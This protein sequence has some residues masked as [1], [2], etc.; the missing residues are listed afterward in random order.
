MSRQ[1]FKTH[2][3]SRKGW[4]MAVAAAQNHLDSVVTSE[5]RNETCVEDF[6]SESEEFLT[7]KMEL[8]KTSS[9]HLGNQ[10]SDDDRSTLHYNNPLL[11]TTRPE[12]IQF[13][14][15]PTLMSHSL[16]KAKIAALQQKASTESSRAIR[17]EGP[18]NNS[19][20]VQCSSNL[21]ADFIANQ[22]KQRLI[23]SNPPMAIEKLSSGVC[24]SLLQST[25]VELRQFPEFKP[26]AMDIIAS[27]K[28]DRPSDLQESNTRNEDEGLL[29]Q[30]VS[31]EEGNRVEFEGRP[32]FLVDINDSGI[33]EG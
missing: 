10:P 6:L 18:C 15:R 30:Q 3:F 26:S 7:V 28:E 11:A 14:A 23:E 12:P 9:S 13:D 19:V 21:I 27:K 31:L 22:N 25:L 2:T 8:S 5:R 32:F 1:V 29:H 17:F 24:Q 20:D 33:V 16:L 4:T